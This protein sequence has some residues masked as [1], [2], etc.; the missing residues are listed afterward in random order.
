[1]KRDKK[2]IKEKPVKWLNRIVSKENEKDK[3]KKNIK[4]I[5]QKMLSYET[6]INSTKKLQ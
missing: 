6:T 4:I 2:G 3:D 5:T 1:M